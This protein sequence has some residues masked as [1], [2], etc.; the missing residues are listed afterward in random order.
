MFLLSAS[1]KLHVLPDY[2]PYLFRH[3]TNMVS[4]LILVSIVVE[5]I[6][7]IYL[8]FSNYKALSCIGSIAVLIV[9]SA[10]LT[11]IYTFTDADCICGA[12]EQFIDTSRD[13]KYLFSIVRNSM[14]IA[15]MMG[16]VYHINF[17][18]TNYLMEH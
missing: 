8:I 7:G 10:Y 1:H 12:G 14:F 18:L 17:K 16:Y 13:G 5:L 15:G 4:N 3:D 2:I 11:Y 6:L 9:Y